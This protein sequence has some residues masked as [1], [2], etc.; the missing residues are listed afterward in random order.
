MAQK[1]ILICIDGTWMTSK[2]QTNVFKFYDMAEESAGQIKFYFEGLGTRWFNKHLG[3]IFGLG[4]KR[5]ILSA[6]S[7]II[8]TFFPGDELHLVGFSRG[9][10]AVRA[11]SGL[12]YFSGVLKLEH[13]DK[14]NAAWKHYKSRGRSST[15][16]AGVWSNPCVVAMLGCFDTVGSIG[17]PFT[18]TYAQG[19]FPHLYPMPN[20]RT[21][22]QALARDE[23]RRFFKQLIFEKRPVG[24]EE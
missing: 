17:I 4:I 13:K 19:W 3:R 24:F 22:R 15:F 18:R 7:A 23:K 2:N 6:Y 8:D 1:N 12:L 9:A 10:Y 21:V 11:L 20:V 14:V 5:Q 16:Q